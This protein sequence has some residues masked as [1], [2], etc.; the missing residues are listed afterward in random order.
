MAVKGSQSGQAL[1]N[2]ALTYCRNGK[3][4]DLS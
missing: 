2:Q 4:W 1:Y 3:G